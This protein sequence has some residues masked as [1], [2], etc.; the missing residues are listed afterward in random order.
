VT[1]SKGLTFDENAA[2]GIERM[3]ATPDV[4]G[5]RARFLQLVAPRP[6]EYVLDVGMGPGFLTYDIAPMVGARGL[7]AGVDSSPV[8]VD[9]AAKRCEGRGPC[10]FKLG[11]ATALPFGDASF[12][13][14]TSAQVYEYVA[15]MPR[16]LAEAHRVLRPHGRLFVLDTDW[17]SVVWNTSDPARMRRVMDA[18]DDHLH[19]AHLPAKLPALLERAGFSLTHVEVIPIVNAALHPH[20]YSHG[21][22]GAIAG[23]VPGHR[24]VDASEAKAW[25]SELRE[26]G[27]RG[28]YFFSINR[29]AFGALR[30]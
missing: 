12:D 16:A 18:W 9:L 7:A 10:E 19:D 4:V 6:G 2:R 13:A 15:D 14:V 21:I 20:G 22:L 1:A 30:R 27:A 5:Q 11:D 26:R 25:A 17:D 8:M 3:Y 28:E 24:G 29:Y 23:F